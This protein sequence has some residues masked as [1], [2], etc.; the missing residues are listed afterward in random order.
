M[1]IKLYEQICWSGDAVIFDE[2]LNWALWIDH[3]EVLSFGR[4][5]VFDAE[6][7]SGEILRI[8][9]MIESMKKRYDK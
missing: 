7:A 8:R 3:E 4:H 5:R 2:S 9:D 6:V 1:V